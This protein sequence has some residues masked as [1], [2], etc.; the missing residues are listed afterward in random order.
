MQCDLETAL[1]LMK[2]FNLGYAK[3]VRH[4]AR[5]EHMQIFESPHANLPGRGGHAHYSAA[6]AESDVATESLV[7]ASVR[8]G[9]EVVQTVPGAL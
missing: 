9:K 7:R 4:Q 8:A 6:S 2:V 3:M 5:Q 1:V